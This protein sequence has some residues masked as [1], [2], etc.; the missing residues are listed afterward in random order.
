MATPKKRTRK[1]TVKKTTRKT[2][3]KRKQ[4]PKKT[5]KKTKRTTRKA[6]TTRKVSR[7]KKRTTKKA[8]TK[9]KTTTRRK[10]TRK[11]PARKTTRKRTSAKKVTETQALQNKEVQQVVEAPKKEVRE[12]SAPTIN[13]SLLKQEPAKPTY[14]IRSVSPLQTPSAHSSM[15]YVKESQ[16]TK[17]P[18]TAFAVS[19]FA[20]AVV[21]GAGSVLQFTSS[22]NDA[23][24]GASVRPVVQQ[25]AGAS[26]E[27]L[28]LMQ[29]Y[30][31]EDFGFD[32]PTEWVVSRAGDTTKLSSSRN[33]SS[34]ISISRE[35]VDK[36]SIEQWVSSDER[37]TNQGVKRIGN[38]NA[39]GYR[40]FE[41]D[42][43]PLDTAIFLVDSEALL[44][45]GSRKSDE[46]SVVFEEL[47]ESFRDIAK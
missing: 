16:P 34:S 10:T 47:I 17:V 7:T 6:S 38:K 33:A 2:A 43:T 26:T 46:V 18:A 37:F 25:V 13:I 29:S 21:L 8:A 45:E 36:D 44:V 42:G 15:P 1:T 4:A 24:S 5:T 3:G 11:S 22:Q 30:R 20:L 19:A 27:E 32:Y 35:V 31:G 41:S 23:T 12:L 9:Q 40:L 39:I 14:M 28:G